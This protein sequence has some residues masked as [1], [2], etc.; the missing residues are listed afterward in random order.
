M[1][2]GGAKHIDED[3][4]GQ[5]GRQRPRSNAGSSSKR[6]TAEADIGQQRG[7]LGRQPWRLVRPL[8]GEHHQ[9]QPRR[10]QQGIE[11][12]GQHTHPGAL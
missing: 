7:Q 9:R 1:S 11:Q 10:Q 6:Q 5:A 12:M 4:Q 8:G 2:V 3:R